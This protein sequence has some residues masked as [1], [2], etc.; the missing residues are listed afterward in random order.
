MYEPTQREREQD[1]EETGRKES[2]TA[3]KP[4]IELQLGSGGANFVGALKPFVIALR[5]FPADTPLEIAIDDKIVEKSRANET[6]E[7]V[8]RV[9]APREAGLHSVTVRDAQTQKVID[10]AMFI[11]RHEDERREGRRNVTARP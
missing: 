4:Y 6:G 9:V 5:N 8:I 7:A 10:G 2:P 1:K 3:G 11:V